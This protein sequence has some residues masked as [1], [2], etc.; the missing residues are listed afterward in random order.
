MSKN[1]YL[2]I[3]DITIQDFYRIL[4]ISPM[5]A[6]CFPFL[7]CKY[8]HHTKTLWEVTFHCSS[9]L[10]LFSSFM[11]SLVA[12]YIFYKKQNVL[13]KEPNGETDPILKSHKQAY[14]SKW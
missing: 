4:N 14:S 5:V 1:N 7:N 6:M 3:F 8:G 10:L 12:M 13:K 11:I 2:R 9:V